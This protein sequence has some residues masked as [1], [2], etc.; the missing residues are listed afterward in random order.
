MKDWATCTELAA[1]ALYGE[2]ICTPYIC[3]IHCSPDLNHLTL[4]PFHQK[5]IAHLDV[6]SFDHAEGLNFLDGTQYK[7]SAAVI[8]IQE[9]EKDMPHFCGVYK[10]L[11]IGAI[12]SQENSTEKFKTGGDTDLATDGPL[13]DAWMPATNDVNEGT[14]GAL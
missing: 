9:S 13:D 12:E 4:R 7:H 8:M 3:H 14:L 10:A 1:L 2:Q 6:L 5:L 11:L